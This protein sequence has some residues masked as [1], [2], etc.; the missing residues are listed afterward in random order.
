MTRPQFK[1]IRI[2]N[3]VAIGGMGKSALTWHWFD[4]IAPQEMQPLAGRL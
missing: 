3:V 4:R 1:P 2:F